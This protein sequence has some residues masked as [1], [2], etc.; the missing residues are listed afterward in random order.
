MK[1]TEKQQWAI[2]KFEKLVERTGSQNKAAKQIGIGAGIISALI[3]G[4]N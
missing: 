4:R 1:Y 2:D 3:S